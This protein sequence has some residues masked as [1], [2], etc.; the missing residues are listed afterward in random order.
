M[1]NPA[2]VWFKWPFRLARRLISFF[3]TLNLLIQIK[4][5]EIL[6]DILLVRVFAQFEILVLLRTMLSALK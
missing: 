2:G 4:I 6:L 1:K 5:S 3:K